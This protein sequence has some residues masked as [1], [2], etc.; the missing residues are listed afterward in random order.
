M[1]SLALPQ[2]SAWALLQRMRFR[3]SRQL[4]IESRRL[5]KRYQELR[6]DFYQ[7]FWYAAADSVGASV[8]DLGFG[9]LKVS[10]ANQSTIVCGYLVQLDDHV[11]L[12]IAGNKP[13]TYRLLAQDG[14]PI[15]RYQ[16]FSSHELGKAARFLSDLPGGKA[17]LKPASNTGG[18]AGV[19]MNLATASDLRSAVYA[20]SVY[21]PNLL[22]EEQVPGHSY[23]LLYLGGEFV[24]AVRRDPP[25]I[26]GNGSNTVRGLVRAENRRRLDESFSALSPLTLD[27]ESKITL[28]QQNLNPRTV[29]PSKSIVTV[30]AVVNQN[31]A[32]ENHCVRESVHP[33]IIELGRTLVKKFRLELAGIDLLAKD[34]AEPLESGGVTI[35]EVNTTPGLHHH[36][37]LADPKMRQSIGEMVLEYI[38][39]RTG[40]NS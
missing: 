8:E 9:F 5:E 27:L 19:T 15:P 4:N 30:K 17:V 28:R 37:L 40:T 12:R 13:L 33:S 22:L 3:L 39:S 38:F 18:G 34:I 2:L 10:R 35:N 11:S 32:K 25:I 16:T 14:L 23:R 1:S 6:E 20:A 26:I 7:R 21:G 29:P 31:T 24:D 36:V